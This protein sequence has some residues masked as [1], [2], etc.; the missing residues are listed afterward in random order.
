[1]TTPSQNQTRSLV[2]RLLLPFHTSEHLQS[3]DMSPSRKELLTSA[4]LFCEDFANKEDITTLI[5]HF[6]TTHQVTAIEHGEAFLAPFLGRV[7]TGLAEVQKYFETIASLLS[8]ENMRFS[9][10]VVDPEARKAAMKGR[11]Q[12][13]W[14]STGES[15]DETFTYML[16]FDEGNKVIR[17]QVW[18][19]SGAAYLASRGKLDETRK[20]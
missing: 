9:E 5:S 17:Y 18:A 13:T 6:S 11:A 2:Y 3:S 12:F 14:L 7:F 8:Y 20:N 19:D 4:Q 15:W 1:M 10:F 16:D